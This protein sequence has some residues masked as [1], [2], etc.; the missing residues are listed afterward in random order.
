MPTDRSAKSMRCDCRGVRRMAENAGTVAGKLK[1]SFPA[2]VPAFS[3]AWLIASRKTR[4]D[5]VFPL[6]LSCGFNDQPENGLDTIAL[7][8]VFHSLSVRFTLCPDG[9]NGCTETFP[10]HLFLRKDEGK[11][12]LFK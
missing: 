2:T 9:I 11:S 8:A 1:S 4:E 10:V 7:A 12:L 3:T 5:R 6:R